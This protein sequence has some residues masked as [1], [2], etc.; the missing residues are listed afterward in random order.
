MTI[1]ELLAELKSAGLLERARR[2][3]CGDVELELDPGDVPR[4]TMRWDL[5]EQ[6]HGTGADTEELRRTE[7]ARA[8]Q[9]LYAAG[10]AGW[11]PPSEYADG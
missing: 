1:R 2:V 4:Q 7:E 10:A 8:L 6:Q 3:K 5:P 9:D 11:T